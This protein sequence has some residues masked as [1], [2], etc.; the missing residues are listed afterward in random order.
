MMALGPMGQ[1]VTDSYVQ[2]GGMFTQAARECAEGDT[3]CLTNANNAGG[4]N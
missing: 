3:E 1:N 4:S 2:I